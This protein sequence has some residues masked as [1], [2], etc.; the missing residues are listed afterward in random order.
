VKKLC[1]PRQCNVEKHPQQVAKIV[2]NASR[3]A[4][5]YE[6]IQLMPNARQSQQQTMSICSRNVSFCD[7]TFVIAACYIPLSAAIIV[8]NWLEDAKPGTYSILLI[9][10]IAD[11]VYPLII[12]FCVF[13]W[14]CADTAA[15]TALSPSSKNATQLTVTTHSVGQSNSMDVY[16]H[17]PTSDYSRQSSRART[18]NYMQ[19][20]LQF[21]QQPFVHRH[22]I[23]FI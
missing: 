20:P 6:Q 4:S 2:E 17:V 7:I 1:C 22:N 5:A 18:Y 13:V 15:T 11:N 14:I 9:R 23:N 16:Q 12:A 8:C 21:Q 19:S 10:L 3:N